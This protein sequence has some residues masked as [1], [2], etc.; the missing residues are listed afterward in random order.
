MDFRQFEGTVFKRVKEILNCTKRLGIMSFQDVRRRR[1]HH[2]FDNHRTTG[3]ST[4]SS[5]GSSS[6]KS[7]SQ[8]RNERMD[9][10]PPHTQQPQQ[11]SQLSGDPTKTQRGVRP[12]LSTS[13]PVTA[14]NLLADHG[15]LSTEETTPSVETLSSQDDLDVRSI[16]PIR[17]ETVTP[18]SQS[19]FAHL[20]TSIVNFQK[21]VAE[22]ENLLEDAGASPEIQ[23]RT[24]ILIHSAQDADR[25]LQARL[26]QLDESSHSSSRAQVALRKLHRDFGRVH[27]D[28]RKVLTLYERKQHVEVS[29][30]TKD[31]TKEDFFE[32][33]MR[34][35]ESDVKKIH[36]SMHQVN[37][38]YQDLAGL[39]D[40]Q[41]DQINR[42]AEATEESKANTRQG[43]EHVK[44]GL[45]GLCAPLGGQLDKKEPDEGYRVKEEFKWSMPFETLGDDIRAVKNDVFQ[46]GRGF[47]ED[48]QDTIVQGRLSGCSQNFNCHEPSDQVRF[49]DSE[50]GCASTKS[51]SRSI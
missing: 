19:M 34:E 47:I 40:D 23:W 21:L 49:D 42:I 31:D 36:Q 51:C 32:R 17:L 5:A 26:Y 2:I 44:H 33:A 16:S 18:R 46:I 39:V 20:T 37:A 50:S 25:D 7:S 14:K 29:F 6:R 43:F 1:Q 9:H 12:R 13:C 48:L 27:K 3:T 22:L 10:E 15:S 11:Q 45:F 30:L 4:T 41:Q 35:R 24:R 28:L 8:P 38:I